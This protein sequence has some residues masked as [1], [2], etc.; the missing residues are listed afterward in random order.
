MYDI[1]LWFQLCKSSIGNAY[2]HSDKKWMM[3]ISL[4]HISALKDHKFYFVN[5]QILCKTED[6]EVL[7]AEVAVIEY[8]LE[9]GIS[10]ELHRFIEPGQ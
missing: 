5:F 9:K 10:K 7:P 4:W 2:G 3:L 6:E 8:S 1:Q